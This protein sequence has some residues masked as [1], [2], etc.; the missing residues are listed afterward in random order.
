MRA[1][2]LRSVATTAFASAQ[3]ACQRSRVAAEAR[4]AAQPARKAGQISA[5]RSSD[6]PGNALQAAGTYF[7]GN[8]GAAG[9]GGAAAAGGGARRRFGDRGRRAGLARDGGAA[10]DDQECRGGERRARASE[11]RG[12]DKMV[13]FFLEAL[14]AL[15][16]A[17]GIVAWTMGPKRRKPP[18]V[19]GRRRGP[20]QEDSLM[21]HARH[22]QRERRESRRRTRCRPRPPSGR[23]RASC[24]PPSPG[25]CRSCTRNSR[26]A[27]AGAA[28]RPRPAPSLPG[29]DARR[30]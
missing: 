4:S 20:R 8:D 12:P 10:R 16:I 15:L 11:R 25:G 7:A 18:R 22:G 23:C 6:Q 2:Q 27:A 1:P 17:V 19:H 30:R 3:G 26:R 13:W 21:Q 24:P 28:G 9:G 14:V 5:T 29:P